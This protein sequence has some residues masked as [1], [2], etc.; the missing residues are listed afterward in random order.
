MAHLPPAELE[1]GFNH[2]KADLLIAR[3]ELEGPLSDWYIIL[4]PC[5]IDCSCINEEEVPRLVLSQCIYVGELDR[6]FVHQPFVEDYGFRVM[7]HCDI[8]QKELAC[9]F[10]M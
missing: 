2:A 10:P 6:F 5:R 8:C 9:G 4:C 3:Q 7:W 1:A